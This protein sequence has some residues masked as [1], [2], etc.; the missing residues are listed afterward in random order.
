MPY[1]SSNV[2]DAPRRAG[3]GSMAAVAAHGD[4]DDDRGGSNRSAVAALIFGVV[5]G[6]LIAIV[7]GFVGRAR[8]KTVGHGRGMATTGLVLG[9][10]WLV[11]Q[12]AYVGV[13]WRSQ[14]ADAVRQH[15]T[16]SSGSLDSGC[17][18][19]EGS[20]AVATMNADARAGNVAK[21]VTDF[22]TLATQMSAAEAKTTRPDAVAAMKAFA[23]DLTAYADALSNGQSFSAADLN[24]FVADAG[25]VDKACAP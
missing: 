2:M 17:A 19:V 3:T 11:A 14:V 9:V 20:D 4:P 15:T 22:R 1:H 10:L 23:T 5:G 24:K 8:A 6:S 7:L 16:Q 21:L 12:G 25:A 13:E 18:A